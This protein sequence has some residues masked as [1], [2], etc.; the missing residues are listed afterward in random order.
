MNTLIIK[1]ICI[2]KIHY[3][4]TPHLV[5]EINRTLIEGLVDTNALMSI[6]AANVV[7]NWHNVFGFKS[8]GV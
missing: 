7:R 3:S 4:K 6:M 1:R 8:R 2:N 5:V